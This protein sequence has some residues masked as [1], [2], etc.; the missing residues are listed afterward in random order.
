MRAER[1][2][3]NELFIFLLQFFSFFVRQH[4]FRFV[5][6]A[7][8]ASS[9]FS[10]SSRIA[11]G[12]SWFSHLT[13]ANYV[14]HTLTEWHFLPEW[15]NRRRDKK[16]TVCWYE[17]MLC[18]CRCCL[19][20]FRTRFF[21]CIN[22]PVNEKKRRKKRISLMKIKALLSIENSINSGSTENEKIHFI[23]FQLSHWINFSFG[24]FS[25]L[26]FCFL[27]WSVNIRH[28]HCSTE[29]FGFHSKMGISTLSKSFEPTS[30]G[31]NLM[32]TV[33]APLSTSFVSHFPLFFFFFLLL[34]KYTQT[35]TNTHN[36][37][38]NGKL[39]SVVQRID[40]WKYIVSAKRQTVWEI[41]CE[42]K[43]KRTKKCISI[44]MAQV[45]N[46]V[47]HLRWIFIECQR[48][49]SE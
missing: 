45:E 12:R 48:N 49:E 20:S 40:K 37:H 19:T 35:D 16:N 21:Y 47:V 31:M 18:E 2:R 14:T 34:S 41:F 28:F 4:S 39:T 17:E 1:E 9:Y 10:H 7:I 13:T 6:F 26:L 5:I 25:F 29:W 11:R 46:D 38:S 23:H 24:F 27:C 32:T 43:R 36:K 22:S 8:V 3:K 44:W 33:D 30:T 42:N 15:E